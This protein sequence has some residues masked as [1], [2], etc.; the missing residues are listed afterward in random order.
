MKKYIIGISSIIA[1]LVIIL[2]LS[3]V[4]WKSMGK[5]QK[6]IRVVTGLNFYGEV[7]QKV[8][9]DHGQ[10]ISFIDNASVD[11]HDYQ[12][13]TKQ[14]QQVA[15]ANVVIENGLGYDSWVN[16]LVKSSSNRNKIKIIDV[17]SLTGKKDGDNEHIWYA[18]E[19]VEKLANDLATQYG[20]I[21]PQHAEDY[22]RNARKYLASLQPLNEEIAKVKRQ[23]NPNNNRVAVSEPVF[24]YALKNAGYQ[25]MDKHFEKA[26]EDGND[27]SPKDI[28]EIQQAIINHQI[29][30]FVDNSQTSDKVVDNLVKLAHEHDVPVLKVTETKPN[31]D[32]Y[33]QWMLK[34]Y[35][36]LSRIQQKEN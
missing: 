2:G 36:A 17:A 22:Q 10:V 16:K 27:P 18:P 31:G 19:T 25:I 21:D 7:A 30:F 8:A 1:L 12:P 33:M 3:F 29:A 26:V 5:S 35:Q 20:K 14:A 6:P 28:E 23:V 13:N 24:D 4:P 32:D 9:G 15:K 11:P 34:Q